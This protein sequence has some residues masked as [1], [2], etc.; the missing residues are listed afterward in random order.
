[1]NTETL[2]HYIQD[3]INEHNNG[4]TYKEIAN[5][6]ETSP[7]SIGRLL[8][9]NGYYVRTKCTSDLENE[10]CNKYVASTD[11]TIKKLALEYKVSERTI[12]NLL[13]QR[14]IPI[15]KSNI[16]NRKY[17][18]NEHYFDTVDSDNKA[19][20]LG[21]LYADGNNTERGT[22]SI[23]LQEQDKSILE[24][25]NRELNYD[26]D[27]IFINYK[28]KSENWSNQYMLRITNKYMSSR[29]VELGVI[30]NKSLLIKFPDWLASEYYP[31]F[32][33]GYFDGDGCIPK[34]LSEKHLSL[35]G[36][37]DFCMSIKNILKNELNIHSS[38]SLCHG[39]S[40]ISTRVL[41]ISGKIQTEKFLDYIYKDSD[42]YIERKYN[43]YLEKYKNIN[44]SLTA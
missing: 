14:N 13:K 32:I 44:N 11:N 19:Y 23:S 26:K 34:K 39:N 2:K 40:S 31:H 8:R 33:R 5:R 43:L 15:I 3:I 24:K 36:T 25:I 30:P 16:L 7:S 37:Y 17:S 29:L 27:L 6:Y 35:I 38:I 28:E 20:I 41:Y 9:S 22:I 21:L 1:M 4:M 12:S 18:I 42:L 10:I